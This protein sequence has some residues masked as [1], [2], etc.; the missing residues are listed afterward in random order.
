MT[1]FARKTLIASLSALTLGTAVI[2][3]AAPAEARPWR[4]HGGAV[5]AGV[6]GGLALGAVA[7]SA[8][9]VYVAPAYNVPSCA[10]VRQPVT[11]GFGNVLYVRTVKVCH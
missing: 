4:Y 11:D 2:A 7:A 8:H 9:T 5:A 1:A 3:S 10:R 6:V